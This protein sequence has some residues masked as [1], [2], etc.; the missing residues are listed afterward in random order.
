MQ[1]SH[2]S[3]VNGTVD[4]GKG[5]FQL[6]T[7]HE[8]GRADALT[9]ESGVPE[10]ELMKN[11]GMRVVE[12]IRRTYPRVPTTILC[13]PGN[14]GGDGFVI[15]IE[16][17]KRGWPVRL[18]L[19][20]DKK[21][22]GAAARHFLDLWGDTEDFSADALTDAGLIVDAMFGAGLDR[23]IVAEFEKIVRQ[24]NKM[25]CPVVAVDVPSGICGETGQVLGVAIQASSTVSFFRFK[26]GHFLYPGRARRG[27]LVLGQIGIADHMAKAV[28][29]KCE[30]NAFQS[31][32]LQG[33]E[34]DHKYN[35]GH[36]LVV[37]GEI[38]KTGAS[39]MS[40]Q[41]ALR[42]GAGL[43]SVQAE[44]EIADELANHLTA[45][46]IK[47]EPLDALLADA[48]YRSIV[49]G[50]GCGVNDQTHHNVLTSLA[51]NRAIVLDADALSVFESDPAE[52]FD[53]IANNSSEVV[54]TP[55]GGEFNRLFPNVS[56][57]NDKVS[58]ARQAAKMAGAVLVLKGAD[59]VIAAPDGRVRI[60]AN[61]PHWLAT[62]GS[63]DVLAGVIGRFFGARA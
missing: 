41:S 49:V 10:R 46:M 63:G 62:A 26:P 11:A 43:V 29:A 33:S 38:H 18:V 44:T 39:R 55:H 7:P 42:A 58:A 9:I 20:G 54:L 4:F 35:K 57:D 6:L 30:V 21:K 47:S 15:G 45:E 17:R 14:N 12:H 60:N 16:L 56:S 23:P 3:P 25:I 59:T 52:L 51:A 24:T 37:G 53:H 28:G 32:W 34:T 31:N 5:G 50:P 19:L 40:A 22:Y 2:L 48:R 1:N 13:G 8:M 36:C 61:A 27:D